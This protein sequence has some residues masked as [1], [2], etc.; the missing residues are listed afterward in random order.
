MCCNEAHDATYQSMSPLWPSELPAFGFAVCMFITLSCIFVVQD[1]EA[2]ELPMGASRADVKKAYRKLAMQVQ[3]LQQYTHLHHMPR[4]VQAVAAVSPRLVLD[5][6]LLS[7][8]A[9]AR[10]HALRA[11]LAAFCLACPNSEAR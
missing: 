4:A 6:H 10:H 2:L 7:W 9:A 3:A 11:K 1:Y 5:A 8:L